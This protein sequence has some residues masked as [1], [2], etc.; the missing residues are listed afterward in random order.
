MACP[1][2]TRE[3]LRADSGSL[4]AFVDLRGC[5][6]MVRKWL[7]TMGLGYRGFPAVWFLFLVE[8]VV[9]LL[10][11][12]LQ[13][14]ITSSQG[15]L[16]CCHKRSTCPRAVNRCRSMRRNCLEDFCKAWGSGMGRMKVGKFP[17][18]NYGAKPSCLLHHLCHDHSRLNQLMTSFNHLINH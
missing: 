10:L 3:V 2:N 13:L 16:G 7:L 4:M 5:A 8:G 15:R 1:L 14:F 9:G 12:W 17:L 11:T 6:S 18:Q